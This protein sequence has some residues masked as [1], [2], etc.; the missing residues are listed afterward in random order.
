MFSWED[1]FIKKTL[2]LR[3]K[4]L[5]ASTSELG[6]FSFVLSLLLASPMFGAWIAV[7]TYHV[8]ASMERLFVVRLVIVYICFGVHCSRCDHILHL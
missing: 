4:E 8:V 2:A 3:E 1:V 6:T 5:Q 7:E